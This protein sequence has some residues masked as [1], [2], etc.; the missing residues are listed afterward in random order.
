MKRSLVVLA[1]CAVSSIAST[2][3]A[4]SLPPP[5]RN[6]TWGTVSTVSMAIGLSTQLLTPRIYWGEGETTLG[7]K[8]RWHVSQLVPVMTVIA[9]GLANE[10]AVKPEIT[11]Y[12]PG[13]GPTNEGVAGCAS[14]GMPSTHSF[15]AFSA[16]GQGTATFLVD[17][18]KYSN[19]RV[20]GASLALNV[21][22]PAVAATFTFLGRSLGDPSYE[23]FDQVGIGAGTGLLV[24]AALGGVYALFQ[25]PECGYG[26]GLVCW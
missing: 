20:N 21:I 16:L 17:T 6:E 11:S 19:G 2:A 15:V 10:Y 13:C 22:T 8:E 14:F 23:H 7:W 24:G 18:L 5:Q 4:Q 1:C 3:S 12:R 25:R 9:I 26:G